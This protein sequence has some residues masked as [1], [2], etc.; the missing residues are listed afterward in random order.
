M[1]TNQTH[2]GNGD[3]VGRDKIV[4]NYFNE[5]KTISK[6][7]LK[8]KLLFYYQNNF[9]TISLLENQK[10]I[11][12][13]FVNL[14]IIK[15]EPK[16]EQ[17]EQEEQK[18]NKELTSRK[19][20]IHY[21]EEIYKP[22]E[23]IEVKEL[24][25]KAKRGGS[26]KALIFGKAG[27]GKTTL[28]KYISY[29]WANEKLYNEFDLIIYVALRE[30]KDGG[31]AKAIKINYF[32]EDE[33]K[34]IK[35]DDI[36][37]KALFLF[38]G[39]DELKENKKK[40][41]QREIRN[42]NLQNYIITSRPYGYTKGELDINEEFETIG[43]TEENVEEYI[44][45]FFK[46]DENKAKNLK[47]YLKNNINIKQI[48]YI[49]LML[50]MICSLHNQKTLSSSLTMT[51]LYKKIK[52]YLL[53]KYASKKGDPRVYLRRNRKK[54]E[55]LLGKIAFE[56]LKRQKILFD[57]ELIEE[58]LE[59]NKIEFFEENI[60]YAGFLKTDREYKDIL[61]R[62]F[63]FIHLTFQEF[64]AALYVSTL[65]KEEIS[66]IIQEYKFYPY[67][68]IFFAFLAGIFED[69]EFLLDEIKKEPKDIL[70]IYKLIFTLNLLSEIK[71][72]EI[73]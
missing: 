27:I 23:P 42:Y 20:I 52:D 34:E 9:K 33:K 44:D 18:Q 51:D 16:K 70:G 14:A 55:K 7:E 15:E 30:W 53:N 37:D 39:Y 73:N 57:G 21:Y 40:L 1:Q 28:C 46:D 58:I 5:I 25:E 66:K 71:K 13:I 17:K 6:E 3:N 38:D 54:I 50:E 36:K 24:I 65:S 68:Q 47:E 2:F 49:P 61:D 59:E 8:E 32:G 64:F 56:A 60:I 35:I 22:K 69:K 12:E 10:N 45:K 63:E 62:K 11:E 67:M 43:F 48:S 31:I 4:N 29:H 41:L 19:N 72:Y 26:S